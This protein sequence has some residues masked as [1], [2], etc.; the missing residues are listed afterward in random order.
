MPGKFSPKAPRSSNPLGTENHRPV[1]L[2]DISIEDIDARRAN[3][4][5]YGTAKECA[6]FLG[7]SYQQVIR[8]IGDR[9]TSLRDGKVYAVREQGAQTR[10]LFKPPS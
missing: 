7:T 5:L 3:A 10:T 9:I 8:K 1:M 6:V 4:L 2:Y